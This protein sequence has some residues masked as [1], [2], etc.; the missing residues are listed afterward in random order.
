MPIRGLLLLSDGTCR[1]ILPRTTREDAVGCPSFHVR[2]LDDCQL[3]KYSNSITIFF[4]WTPPPRITARKNLKRFDGTAKLWQS[5][6]RGSILYISK[7]VTSFS[8]GL[9]CARVSRDRKM[10]PRQG[11]VDVIKG[12]RWNIPFHT[13]LFNIIYR[14]VG[15]ETSLEDACIRRQRSSEKQRVHSL[16]YFLFDS[17]SPKRKGARGYKCYYAKALPRSP[18]VRWPPFCT[19]HEIKIVFDNSAANYL[20]NKNVIYFSCALKR[21]VILSIFYRSEKKIKRDENIQRMKHAQFHLT[22]VDKCSLTDVKR[23]RRRDRQTHTH[24]ILAYKRS[25][26]ANGERESERENE[27]EKE[28][29]NDND[30][31][32]G[33][34]DFFF[35]RKETERIKYFI[36]QLRLS[37][38]I[39]Q[40]VVWGCS[41]TGNPYE[42]MNE[43]EFHLI[44]G[45]EWLKN[46]NNQILIS[47]EECS[48]RA[49]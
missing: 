28:S 22:N 40:E 19:Y 31:I 34:L 27:R 45:Y 32:L 35:I 1:V 18:P 20:N 11:N 30:I 24:T 46:P 39:L 29:F 41:I 33:K 9:Q 17:I 6:V 8:R 16:W 36:Q 7:A 12:C 44:Y 47:R 13:T 26:R 37:S 42:A 2:P 48:I 49:R 43:K 25:P 38:N 14:H 10:I 21:N 15:M 3:E 4:R 5:W 23:S